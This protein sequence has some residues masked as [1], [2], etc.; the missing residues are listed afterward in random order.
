[1]IGV[2]GVGMDAPKSRDVRQMAERFAL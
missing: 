2:V 1:V